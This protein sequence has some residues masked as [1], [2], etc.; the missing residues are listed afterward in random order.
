M[1]PSE[2]HY[3]HSPTIQ[4]ICKK[5]IFQQNDDCKD[6]RCIFQGAWHDAKTEFSSNGIL[7]ATKMMRKKR[8]STPY[9]PYQMDIMGRIWTDE[10]PNN[11]KAKSKRSKSATSKNCGLVYPSLKINL[12]VHLKITRHRNPDN[13]LN[14]TSILGGKML[15]F[16]G[17]SVFCLPIQ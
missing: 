14:Q 4:A 2:A 11:K 1:H 10:N 12:Q 15:I 5:N 17:V 3:A 9:G 8:R 16:Q 6:E 13:H 7:S